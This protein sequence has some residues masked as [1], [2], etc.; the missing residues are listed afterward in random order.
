MDARRVVG[1]AAAP[2]GQG[3]RREPFPACPEARS[4]WCR[5]AIEGLGAAA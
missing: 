5:Q 4:G 1:E 2:L 3:S